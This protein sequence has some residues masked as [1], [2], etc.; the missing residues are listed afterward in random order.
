MA[1][2]RR[3]RRGIGE[4]LRVQAAPAV[5]ELASQIRD[6]VAADIDD[7][8]IEVTMTPYTTDRGA[9]AVTIADPEGMELQAR[10]GAL[11]RA[12]ASVGLDVSANG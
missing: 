2:F 10:D 7:E 12:A 8:T 5:N 11:T 4:I 9:A 3:D 6:K 1:K